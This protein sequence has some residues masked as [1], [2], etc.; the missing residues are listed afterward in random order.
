MFESRR[1]RVAPAGSG[2]TEC[3]TRLTGLPRTVLMK[4]LA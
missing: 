3:A 2:A 4:G 1:I